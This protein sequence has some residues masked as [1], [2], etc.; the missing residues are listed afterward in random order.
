MPKDELDPQDPLEPIAVALTSHEDTLAPMAECFIEEFMR[1]GYDAKQI[2]GMFMD[3]FY[4]AAHMALKAK[5]GEF[6][7]K[8][9]ADT[10][11]KWGRNPTTR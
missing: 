10:F 11:A 9:I 4:A 1:M 3:P 5:G 8:L 2:L 7:E 6:I